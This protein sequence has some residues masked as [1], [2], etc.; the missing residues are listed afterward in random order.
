M[1][2]TSVKKSESGKRLNQKLTNHSVR[3]IFILLHVDVVHLTYSEAIGLLS[4]VSISIA[5]LQLKTIIR[6]VS[7]LPALVTSDM[8]QILLSGCCWVGTV[9]VVASSIPISILGAIV[10]M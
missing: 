4:R 10:V 9:L 6:I 7:S 2:C 1:R 3:L 8:T 5:I